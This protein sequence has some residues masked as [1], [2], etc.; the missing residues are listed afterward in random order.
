MFERK[1]ERELLKWKSKSGRKPL[2][3]RGARQT[4][5]T[6]LVRKFARSFKNF[7]ELNLEKEVNQKIFSE[8]KDI[9]DVVQSIEGISN[10]RVIPHETLLFLDEVQ[11]SVSAIKLLRYFYEEM[12]NLHVISAGSLLEV[13]MKTEGWSFPVGRVEFL[14][15]Y[16]VTFDEFLSVTGEEVLLKSLWEYGIEKSL[17]PPLHDRF[18]NLLSDYMVVGGMPEAVNEYI[19]ER[20]FV[21]VRQYHETLVS[22]FK[23]DFSKYS[24]GAEATHLKLVWDRIPF[25]VGSRITY[26]KLAG[27]NAHSKEI[28]RAFDILHEAMLIERIF[29]TTQVAPPLVKKTK[30]APKALFLDIGL[31]IAALHLTKDQIHEQ[32]VDPSYRGG[33][34]EAFVGQELMAL[35]CYQRNALF[36]WIREEKGASSELDFVL[37][38]ENTL[39]PLEVKSGSQGSLKSLHQFLLRSSHHV[40]IRL[41][42][43]PLKV[44]EHSVLLPNSGKLDYQLISIPIYLTF[45]LKEI[46]LK[47]SRILGRR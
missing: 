21:A 5:K 4:G 18:I 36:F 24:K 45:R 11:N 41:Y 2:I 15:L 29:P 12:P 20:S 3:F 16:P 42:N 8:V 46:I 17:P 43:G 9:K 37:P 38:V 7:I 27:A 1:I 28:S 39:I 30:A 14:Y 22:S 34:S 47:H 35:D 23:E 40:G 31:C 26:S 19:K 33:L 6:T 32:F 13:R 44:E 25:E 10:Q